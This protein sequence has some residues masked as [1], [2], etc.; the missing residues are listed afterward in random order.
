ML[1]NKI[2]IHAYK[3][4]GWLYRTWEFP[5]II[6]QTNEYICVSTYNAHVITAS[7]KGE[8][9]FHSC[10]TYPTIWFFFKQKWYNIIVSQR[11]NKN[12]CYIN[13]ASPYFY[14]E[15]AIKYVDFDLDFKVSN[16]KF[17][18]IHEVDI[19]EFN[20]NLK[21]YDYPPKLIDKIKNAENEIRAMFN[22]HE[23]DKYLDLELLRMSKN[24]IH[25]E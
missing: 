23:L 3:Y 17:S 13:I 7:K 22:N 16:L 21:K 6:K 18:A 19:G 5:T 12:Y 24:K 25:H 8:R 4:N 15:E 14:E 20:E 11:G 1:F 10:V 9:H 2:V